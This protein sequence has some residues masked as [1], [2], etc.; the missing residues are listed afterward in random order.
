MKT[1]KVSSV[2]KLIYQNLHVES[3]PRRKLAKDTSRSST[4]LPTPTIDPILNI[5]EVKLVR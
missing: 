1:S 3:I 2:G 4:S 5:Q